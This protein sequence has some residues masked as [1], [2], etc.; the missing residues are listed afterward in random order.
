MTEGEKMKVGFVGLGN[1]GQ[2][3]ARRLLQAGHEVTVYNRTHGRAEA[4]LAD[5]AVIAD[6]PAAAALGEV[7]ITMVSDDAALEAVV[8]G[9]HGFLHSLAPQSIHLSMS[10]ISVELAR[11]LDNDHAAAGQPFVSAPVFGRP[12]AAASGQLMFVVAGEATALERCEPLFT[13]MGQRAFPF[14]E[15]PEHANLVKISGNFL[16]SAAIESL[17]EAFALTRKG[18]IDPQAFLAFLSNS[19]FAS[20][21]YKNYGGMIANQHYQSAAGFKLPLALKDNRLALAA[22]D[23]E[24]VPMPV[25]SL[26]HDELLSAI[27]RGYKD[28][29]MAALGKLSAENA[30]L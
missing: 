25:A 22:A 24:G 14:G 27:A 20:P 21:V 15:T 7:V 11:R 10:T 23:A 5:G 26:V 16:L 12:D 19:L 9:A 4:L 8:Y 13:A 17:G 3:M 18:G 28:L 6:S 29:D 1:M 30:G 2:A